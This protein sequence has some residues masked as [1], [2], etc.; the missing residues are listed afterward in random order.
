LH[1]P[2]FAATRQ[3]PYLLCVPF[4]GHSQF[5]SRHRSRFTEPFMLF[6]LLRVGLDL[7]FFFFPLLLQFS[8]FPP[9]RASVQVLQ[10]ADDF[11]LC[12]TRG[13]EGGLVLLSPSIPPEFSFLRQGRGRRS[14]F[15]RLLSPDSFR[16]I[17]P[18]FPKLSA[19]F[20]ENIV[21]PAIPSSSFLLIDCL[22]QLGKA[23]ADP[24][25]SFLFLS[26]VSCKGLFRT[27][28]R[29]GM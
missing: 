14:L 26:L 11:S 19:L 17:F 18:L 8:R 27:V 28:R 15:T 20:F 25:V 16:S 3:A 21:L 10:N 22:G 24:L 29:S 5:S 12:V 23:L 7:F 2:I 9:S 1:R 4:L 13:L 6:F